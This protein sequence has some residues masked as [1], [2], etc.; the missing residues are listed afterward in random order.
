[1]RR[2]LDNDGVPD[3]QDNCPSVSNTDQRDVDNDGLGDVCDADNDNDG[4]HD[5]QDACLASDLSLTVVIGACDTRVT[6]ALFPTGCTISDR[7]ADCAAGARNH[8]AFVSCVAK[9]TNEL[10]QTGT[11]TGQQ[12]GA[13]QSCAARANIP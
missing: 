12:K 6:N 8:G 10:Q 9:L 4:I 2:D 7:I 3:D 13:I 5:G 11:I 1:M